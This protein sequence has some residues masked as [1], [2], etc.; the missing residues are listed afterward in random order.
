MSNS[1]GKFVWYELM[2]TDTAGAEAFYRGVIGWDAQ[3]SDMPG[4]SYTLFKA[5]ETSV[6]GMMA[7]PQTACAEGARPGWIGYV[8]VDDVDA[9]ASKQTRMAVTST[10]LPMIFPALAALR[11]FPIRRV[12]RSLCSSHRHRQSLKVNRRQPERR[13]WRMARASCRRSR[14]GVRLLRKAVR[15]EKGRV[16][17]HGSD[18]CLPDLF[19]G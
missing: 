11:S 18:G 5:G 4:M 12:Q 13:P 17:R 3:D 8:T 9:S 16:Y 6:G 7:L 15:M 10:A 19:H 2:T 14:G 1:H